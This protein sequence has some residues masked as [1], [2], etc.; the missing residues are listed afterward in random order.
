MLLLSSCI[1]I[2]VF[3]KVFIS[4]AQYLTL[5]SLSPGMVATEMIPEVFVEENPHLKP[6]DLADAV[7]YVLGTPQ[8][9]Q[10]RRRSARQL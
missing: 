8:H 3:Y 7:V 6:E 5:Q 2:T 9:V 10:V 1:N 4:K